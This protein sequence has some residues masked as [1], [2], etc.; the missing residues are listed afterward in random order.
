M[1]LLVSFSLPFCNSIKFISPQEKEK[2]NISDRKRKKKKHIN[3]HFKLTISGILPNSLFPCSY[4]HHFDQRN[5]LLH[6]KVFILFLVTCVGY[7]DDGYKPTMLELYTYF[8]WKMI[9]NHVNMIPN[10][11]LT[12]K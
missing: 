1:I 7:H 4:L 12:R 11:W 10:A 3:V 8:S 2:R 5:L 6:N 9:E